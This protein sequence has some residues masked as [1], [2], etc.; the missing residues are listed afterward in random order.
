VGSTGA[1]VVV[2]EDGAPECTVVGGACEGETVVGDADAGTLPFAA[3]VV[4]VVAV[5]PWVPAVVGVEDFTGLLRPAPRCD[6]VDVVVVDVDTPGPA[7]EP[8]FVLPL[9]QPATIKI[10]PTTSA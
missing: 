8:C 1:S 9:E 4:D 3:G 5:A 6:G 2:G 7:A 10:T